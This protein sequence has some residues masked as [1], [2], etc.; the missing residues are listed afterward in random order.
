MKTVADLAEYETALKDHTEYLAG[1]LPDEIV[2][3][4][5][6]ETGDSPSEEP[7][8]EEMLKAIAS[9]V[10]EAVKPIAASVAAIEAVHKAAGVKEKHKAYY[11]SLSAEE[12]QDFLAMS[13]AERDKKVG[14]DPDGDQED[15]PAKKALA[16]AIAKNAANDVVIKGLVEREEIRTF[17]KKATDLGLDAKHG[18]IIRKAYAGDADARVKLEGLMKGLAEAARVGKVFA[19]FG[20]TEGEGVKSA[21]DEMDAEVAALRKADPKL[22]VAKAFTAVYTDPSKADLK[23]RYDAETSPLAKKRA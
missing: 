18:E 22:S 23:K 5:R 21:A 6:A 19:E 17:E 3:A 10:A 7:M 14:K 2:K 15:T 12:K 9:A 8:N 16:D 4:H 11:A 13:E 1:V 20:T